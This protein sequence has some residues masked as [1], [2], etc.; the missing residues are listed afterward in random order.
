MSS[1]QAQPL[2]AE[3]SFNWVF[4]IEVLVVGILSLFFLFYFNR[5]FAAVV[6]YVIR[7][8]VFRYYKAWIDISALQISLL[9]GRIFFK[10]IRY[11]A[12]NVTLHV[13]EGHITWR[14]WLR[15]VKEAE[16]FQDEDFASI[17]RARSPSISTGDEKSNEKEKGSARSR[18]VGKEERATAKPKKE[19]PCRISVKVSGVEAFIY[20]RSPVYDAVVEAT[21][22]KSKQASKDA[23]ES[24]ESPR[25]ETSESFRSAQNGTEPKRTTTND[26]ATSTNVAAGEKPVIP[27]FLR[28]FPIKVE[29]KKAAA[30]LGNEST[31]NIIVAKTEKGGGTFD[32]G[33]AGP[34]DIWQVLMNFEVENVVVQMKPNRDYKEQ[35]LD[36]A[37][38]VLREMELEEPQLST[39]IR[40]TCSKI[41]GLF[42]RFKVVFQ[43]PRSASDS[44]RTASV[45]SRSVAGTTHAP[46]DQLPGQQQWHGLMRYLDDGEVNEHEEWSPI[47]YAK[48]SEL[49]NVPKVTMRFFWDMPGPVPDVLADG[50]NLQDPLYDD[51][52][53][54]A[55]PPA[56]GMDLGVYGGVVVYG[57]WADRQR[58][59]LQP[60]FVPATYV[61]ATPAK[62][63]K[64]G[65]YRVCT[66]F[67]IKVTVEDDVV[68]R[69]PTREE[70]K[71]AKWKGRADKANPGDPNQNNETTKGD[72]KHWKKH[73]NRTRRKAKQATAAVD[74]RP[75]GW[76]DVTVKK[77]SVVNFNMDMYPRDTGYRNTLDL[78]VKGVEM[79][80]SVN[81]GLL[82]K[83]GPV[84][85]D[86]DI[87]Q[88][89]TWNSLRKW[90]FN[91][92]VND[93]E[94]FILR[95]HLFLIIDIV[96]DWASGAPSE[97]YTF[98][99][100][101]YDLD[102]TFNGFC[103]YL[104][105]NDAN[106]I[107]D[108]ADFDRNDFLTLE[109][110]LH[111][112]L[113]I[114]ME[115]YRP[116]RNQ[117]SFD[118]LASDMKMRMIS[119]PKSTFHA[120]VEDKVMVT[121]PKLTLNGSFNGN[122][123]VRVGN[124]DVL[125]MD[126]VGS[127]LT[128]KAFGFFVRQLVMV[129]ENYFGDYMHFKTLEEF[130]EASDDL[131]E[132]NVKTA[133]FPKPT[134]INE[135]DVVLCIVAEEATI[136]LPT[137]LY[138]CKEFIR[139]EL[140]RADLDLRI[141]SYYLDMGLQLSPV[142]LLTGSSPDNEDDAPLDTNSG[143]QVYCS[144]V[145]LNGHR[146]FGLPPNEDAY[147]SQ[148]D[149]DI[150]KIT[151]EMS[152][153]FVRH[154]ALAGRALTFTIDDAENALPVV[155]PAVALDASFVQVKTDIVRL[156]VHVG[157]DALL[158]ELE[159]VRVDV[160]GWASETFSQR[161]NVMVPLLT[162]ACVDAR[163]ASRYRSR[164]FRKNGVR[165]YAFLQT[166]VS[167]DVVGRNAHFMLETKKQQKHFKLHD[168]RT[169]RFPFLV[170]PNI[171]SEVQPEDELDFE[172]PSMP[173][174]FPPTPVNKKGGTNRPASFKS[175]I[176]SHRHRKLFSRASSSSLSASI[177]SDR[178]VD[179]T[180]ARP[181]LLTK[182]T[183][184]TVVSETSASF[185]SFPFSRPSS[186]SS[187][188]GQGR[189]ILPTDR[190]RAKSGLPASTMAFSSPYS[191]PYFPLEMVRPDETN[192]P[193]FL[194]GAAGEAVSETSSISELI[195]DPDIDPESE[196]TSVMIKILPGIRAYVEPRVAIT[197]SK[198]V[199]KALPK[200]AEEVMDSFQTDVLGT[201]QAQNASK[202]AKSNIVEIQA[203]LA[204]AH[205]R[206]VALDESSEHIAD[207]VD[208]TLTGL[209]NAVR[210]RSQ[211]QR[212]AAPLQFLS[213]HALLENLEVEL[214][215]KM[216]ATGLPAIRLRVDDVLVWLSMANSNAFHLSFRDTN[217]AVTGSQAKYLTQLALKL[218]PIV[219]DVQTRFEDIFARDTRR[220]QTMSYVMTYNG[221][222]VGDPPFMGRL[223]Y[224]LRVVPTHLRN[225][226]SWKILARFRYILMH[227]P[228][229]VKKDLEAD[230]KDAKLNCPPD[231]PR[232]VLESWT[233]SRNWDVP[234]VNQTVAFQK[235]HG[236]EITQ[237]KTS[238][239]KETTVTFRSESL[240]VAIEHAKGNSDIILEETS[241]GLENSPP[242]RPE[243]L[244]LVDENKRTKT[245]VQMHTNTIALALDWGLFYIA[246]DVVSLADRIE[247]VKAH[248]ESHG[249]TST[250][251]KLEEGLARHDINA[252][253]SMGTG[254][255]SVRSA[256]LRH[257]SR[258]DGLK[259]SI[260]G[261]TQ[262]N[263][264]LG[265]CE[266]MI[267]NVDRAV[268]ELHSSNSRI[269]QTLITSP[270]IYVDH[271]RP[272][273]GIDKPPTVTLAISYNDLQIAITEQVPG[274][275]Q[276]VDTIITE[277]VA[278]CQ[279]LAEFVQSNKRVRTPSTIPNTEVALSRARTGSDQAP[280]L[281]V[282]VLAGNLEME[283]SL[284]STLSY[285]LKG[286]AAGIRVAPSLDKDKVFSIDFDVGRQEHSFLNT[287][288]KNTQTQGLLDVPPING[289][290]GLELGEEEI[291]I[292][293]AT[294][295]EKVQVDAGAIQGL[296]GV[297]NRPEVQDIISAI[298]VGVDGMKG[299]VAE[300]F[301]E[302]ETAQ[303]RANPKKQQVVFDTRLALL[304]IRVSTSTPRVVGNS[305]A[306]VEFGI[307]PL[308]ATA[309]N[310][311]MPKE[312]IPEVRMHIQ[313]IGASLK[314]RERGKLRPCG[315]AT[316]TVSLHFKN[317]VGEQGA[318]TRSLKVSSHGP[319][320]NAYPETAS[321]IIDVINHLQD[322]IKHLDLSKEVENLRR[323]RD[324]RRQTVV[325]KIS[326][327]NEWT[328]DQ[329]LPFSPEDLLAIKT[330]IEL[331]DIQ[332][333]WLVDPS[334]AA[335]KR[336]K[337]DD[338]VFSIQSIEFT[339]R[340]GNEARLTI[341]DMMLQLA[342]KQDSKQSR[343]L[344]SGLLPE[345]G[346]SVGYWKLDDK[347]HVAIKANGKPLDLRLE[348]RF[349]LPVNAL[350]KSIELAIDDAKKG[351]A[352]W[353]STPTSSGAPRSSTTMFDNKH[354]GSLLVEADFA[355]AKVY[356]QGS[357]TKDRTLSTVA[358][359]SL[360][361]YGAQHGRYGQFA[362][363]GE[364]L[365]TT[366]TA[367]GIAFKIEYN[368]LKQ[369]PTVNA[370]LQIDASS[371]MLLPNVVPLV[372]EVS[373]SVK[374]LVRDQKGDSTPIR[375]VPVSEAAKP[376]QKFFDTGDDS[377]IDVTPAKI[378][379]KTKVDLG[380]RI[381]KQE[382]GL[383]CQPIARVDA[384]ASLEDF[385]V[386]M[387]TIDSD[388]HGHFFATSAVLTGL[389]A[390]VKHVYSREPTFSYDMESIVLSAMNNKHLS[391]QSGISA[392]L[393]V[394]P[395]RIVINGKQFQDLLLF[396]EI[397]LP[398]EI[399][400][401]AAAAGGSPS[402]TPASS[403]PD[404][405][406]VQKYQTVAAAAAFPWNATVSIAKLSVDVDLGQSIGKSSFSMTNLWASQ[407][408]TSNWEQNLCIG[409]DEMA[410]NSTGRMSGFIK[411]AKLGIRTSIRWPEETS[412][413]T[414]QKTPL[415]Q[416][417]IGFHKLLAKAAFDYQAFAFGDI[418]GFDF[419]MYNVQDAPGKS[420]RLVAV[421]DCEKAYVFCTSTSAAQAV[422]LYQAFDR[423]IQE[424][425]AAYV[426]SLRD[427]EKHVR[428]ES[429][430][431]PTRFG[432]TIP[433][434]PVLEK[435]P[436]D[437]P[438]NLH[439]DVV[440]TMGAI[441]FGVYPSTFFDSQ[442][443]KLEANN[444][445]ARFA[446]GLERGRV[447]SGLGMTLGQLQVAL[448]SVRRVTAV[449]KALEVTV[450]EV[451]HSALN[452]KG[453]IILRVPK[454]VASM[455]SWQTPH[456]NEVD[457]IFK[458]LFDGKIDVGWNLSRINFIKGMWMS[459]SKAL[460]QRLDR[461]SLPES[462][463]KIRAGPDPVQKLEEPS[464]VEETSGKE[465]YNAQEKITAEINLPQS[466]YEYHALEP[467]VIET[468][469]L[470]DMG[471]ATPPLEWIGLHRDRLP[472]V[473]HQ[474]LIVSLL[475]VCKEV[476]EAY[477]RILGSR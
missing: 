150:G 164:N 424:K 52:I 458:S 302:G 426:Q 345:I 406:L 460:A 89:C 188:E 289:H 337:V 11:H 34:L 149:I 195:T 342:K 319:E 438:I 185:Y 234:Y 142:S 107:N 32:A 55:A 153:R 308:H 350:Q 206:V 198:L 474:I 109:G 380:F 20:N 13:Y 53:N 239:H 68:L 163:S 296:I 126:L 355:G 417:S 473:T 172:P 334:F 59:N 423:L 470:R 184:T 237:L 258:A 22:S 76:L 409:L 6:S 291:V 442:M 367:P 171:D 78:D 202:L 295:V 292:S 471:E 467:P 17:G 270:S 312:I 187:G 309:S 114:P 173:Y 90:P 477:E 170:R 147:V 246:E 71:D 357:T 9:G 447:T 300:I 79:S 207:Q 279:R 440:V 57:P 262:A 10:K 261:T 37:Q 36:Q 108:P 167:L 39:P 282:A 151:G 101:T 378:F 128:L 63:L 269:W 92:V 8:Y 303:K 35:Q 466:R 115:H 5:L 77:D 69:I 4:E 304:G 87:S 102:I 348:S 278:K 230:V 449:P 398:P 256:S 351:T 372:L 368:S 391:G 179:T 41:L 66:V 414:L 452:A 73:K 125:R 105:V 306:E 328:E 236:D 46:L 400:N 318:V 377:I 326:G 346:F 280:K 349:V 389:K 336:A 118:V 165:T 215:D 273:P 420:D 122:Q 383:S 138:S 281:H 339:T 247:E 413:A 18:S 174:P 361:K 267:M 162:L 139:A 40:D 456:S 2:N 465:Q 91:I 340:S 344:N 290:V 313:D 365:H 411:L 439:T 297:I 448:S 134:S 401:A 446:A 94:L 178:P 98:V 325:Q 62:S 47:E 31:K 356:M 311:A 221:D 225:T 241:L 454:V 205:I 321:T 72:G 49:V 226:D 219:K 84:I 369:Q 50:N 111:A 106:I 204:S 310:K 433:E 360:Q 144:H 395:T 208:L 366:L 160:A 159:P 65:E 358:A 123:E 443:L 120:F 399:R 44:L 338:L 54:G 421:L 451:T 141:V 284:L 327:K 457:Y 251:Q 129:K 301:P 192:V 97:F 376:A 405:F 259:M 227:L 99:P 131:Q 255:I 56:Y 86:A 455:Q 363:E 276:I 7:L 191:E 354:L 232:H 476:E 175:S 212:D 379:G 469:Q 385:Y 436:K 343:S 429:T 42:S 390:Q 157:K 392:I 124:V 43:L 75:Y 210:I 182:G 252:V 265:Q 136:M 130:Q 181:S 223:L 190:E 432:P 135:L 3:R 96:N 254:S 260:L 286:T 243:G 381:A 183:N 463:V 143:T 33:H 415:I 88:P 29:C 26:T 245:T 186:E 430:I 427:I 121:L 475:E 119:P 294:T 146:S 228:P 112:V 374:E 110:K 407:A 468:P 322:R 333:C 1:L 271:L 19:L 24:E 25:S 244:M 154:L 224:V 145:E 453:G 218:I 352:T 315:N 416:A 386:T 264:E 396:R 14:Y 277:E 434:S 176:S 229:G 82:W 238:E 323:M 211:P 299:H 472:N 231:T 60:I 233:Q 410:V 283:V 103:M 359:A 83:S 51:D 12:H 48:A 95:D 425:Q 362:G 441:C 412:E 28:I 285:Q 203:S 444:I 428:R 85:L 353:E 216:S 200:T 80:S 275:L 397:W 268:T 364:L 169:N 209:E 331:T 437:S 189:R 305:T 214:N 140:P 196:H 23:A 177:R 133:S 298:K 193:A 347:R 21:M 58:L 197:A 382:F 287:S 408:K 220:L 373:N 371:N 217:I 116:K 249:H 15:A 329:E 168:Q 370:E 422:G 27:S 93:L 459:G 257:V 137:N 462:A 113:G 324:E 235:L 30:A 242:S 194:K 274:I 388:E 45:R 461:K 375:Q 317:L 402:A 100:Y 253:V 288:E 394:N 332:A 81:H 132:A 16:V 158:L 70:S 201:I 61:D 250:S 127:G 152:S 445:Q 148:W 330:T 393:N 161:V 166:G 435:K 307:G 320:V 314:I 266:S 104:N 272:S 450:D 67:Q 387:N 419:L 180:K 316:L 199:K 74:A 38:R 117:I 384:K 431:V 464:K 404:E 335:N 222:Q 156:W 64:P 263:E 418:E 403:R 293:V 155:S 248:L 240:R 341:K 213:I